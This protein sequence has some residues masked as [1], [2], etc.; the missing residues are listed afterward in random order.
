MVRGSEVV[1]GSL[2]LVFQCLGN[3]NHLLCNEI[4][5]KKT[6]SIPEKKKKI[7]VKAIIKIQNLFFPQ[8]L[9]SGGK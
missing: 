6:F 5:G 7:L 3:C 8:K 4:F 9:R 1:S 2:T